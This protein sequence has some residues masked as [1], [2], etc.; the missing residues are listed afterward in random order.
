MLGLKPE[1]TEFKVTYGAA[2]TQ[3]GE[4]AIL[5]RSIMD[6]I[7]ELSAQIEVPTEQ[8]AEGRTYAT[9]HE[10]GEGKGPGSSSYPD[11]LQ[12]GKTVRQ[13]C[14]HQQP[15]LLVLD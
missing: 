11:S 13:L 14:R 4:V 5:T 1:T 3:E 9:S 8:A 6:I 12:Q 7:I 2:P 15:Q 10:I